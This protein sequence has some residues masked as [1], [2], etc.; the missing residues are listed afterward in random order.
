MKKDK[1]EITFENTI[2]IQKILSLLS[3]AY[4]SS[5]NKEIGTSC[6]RSF[7]TTERVRTSYLIYK[8]NIV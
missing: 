6:V 7:Q 5:R 1:N 8:E 3:Q 2:R 4:D